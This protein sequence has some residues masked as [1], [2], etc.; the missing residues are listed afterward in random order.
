MA[1]IQMDVK[2][3]RSYCEAIFEKMGFTGQESRGITDVLLTADLYGIESHGV[4]R[5]IRY[6]GALE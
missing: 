2:Q 3:V 4:Q 5:L 1:Y 6:Y